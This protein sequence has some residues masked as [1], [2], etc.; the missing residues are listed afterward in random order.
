[1]VTALQLA[2]QGYASSNPPEWIAALWPQALL[3]S[4]AA[5]DKDGGPD[6]ET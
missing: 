5:G 2:D 4:E 6:R 3:L 1:M